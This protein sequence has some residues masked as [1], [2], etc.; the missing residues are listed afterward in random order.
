MSRPYDETADIPPASAYET[1]AQ[2]PDNPVGA[3]LP[4]TPVPAIELRF[5]TQPGPGYDQQAS[6]NLVRERYQNCAPIVQY[7]L[8]RIV[9]DSG[10]RETIHRLR[11]EGWLDWHILVTMANHLANHRLTW[12]GITLPP[13]N[14]EASE[15]AF[16]IMQRPERSNDPTLPATA[17]SEQALRFSLANAAISTVKILGLEIHQQTPDFGAILHLLGA[18]YGYWT[19]DIDHEDFFHWSQR[20]A[21]TETP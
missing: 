14:Q 3:D 13:A 10:F 7:T 5:P 2:A 19:D 15:R 1:M 6:L 8:P 16:R 21:Q 17:F 4:A 12:E 20:P 9:T 11:S 18:Q